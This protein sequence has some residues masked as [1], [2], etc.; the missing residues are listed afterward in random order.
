MTPVAAPIPRD[1]SPRRTRR[2]LPGA[3]HRTGWRCGYDGVVRP[4]PEST[5]RDAGRPPRAGSCRRQPPAGIEDVLAAPGGAACFLPAELADARVW[6]ITCQLPSLVSERNCGIGDFADLA[7]LCRIAAEAGADFVGV[8]PLHALFWSDPDRVSP[9]FA[10][11]PA[12]PQ[13]DLY[14]ARLG[15]GFSRSL[16]GRAA[17]RSGKRKA[18]ETVDIALVVKV[19]QSRSAAACSTAM[20]PD[21]RFPSASARPAARRS[22]TTRSSRRSR[23]SM[24]GQGKGATPDTWPRNFRRQAVERRYDLRAEP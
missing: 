6:G 17:P 9:F 22:P 13:S 7:A 24:V 19:K 3:W 18:A 11:Q 15:R 4:V 14:R 21:A 10:V 8:N 23:R 1:E 5:L 2:A 16:G 20:T 12:L